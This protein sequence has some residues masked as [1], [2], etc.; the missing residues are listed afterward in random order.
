MWHMDQSSIYSTE[1]L[2]HTKTIFVL[3]ETGL[4]R[5]WSSYENKSTLILNQ[6]RDMRYSSVWAQDSICSICVDID[7]DHKGV[8][9][10]SLTL[11][12]FEHCHHS[13]NFMLK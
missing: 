9:M 11:V 5:L 10:S 7:M 12:A 6:E 1:A 8:Y 2:T 4:C 13:R 3:C